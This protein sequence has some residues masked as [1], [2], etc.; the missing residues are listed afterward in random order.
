MAITTRDYNLADSSPVTV[1]NAI[2]SAFTD[3]AWAEA[4]QI[5]Y[6]LTFTNTAGS[7]VSSQINKRYVVA[8]TAASGGT[9]ALFDVLRSPYGGILAVTLVT[10]GSGYSI[11]G[12][13][14]ATGSTTTI[15]VA[16]TT[17]FYA[18]MVV[19][20]LAGGTGVLATNTVI[21]SVT[22]STT[23]VID[24]IPTTALS[25]ASIQVSDVLTLSANNI[26]GT[27]YTT[28]VTATAA[29]TTLTVTDATNI[30]VGQ[31]VTGT[32]IGS[33]VTVTAVN[34]TAVTISKATLNT[35]TAAT[36]TF[37]DE[38]IVTA[39]A[40]ANDSS[41][42]G[43]ITALTITNVPTSAVLHVGQT[44]TISSGS[45]FYT[46]DGR[47]F[48]GAIAGTGPYTVTLR[49]AANTFRGFQGTGNI[50]FKVSQDSTKPWFYYDNFTAPQ[51]YAFGVIK[52][53]NSTDRFGSTF[54]AVYVGLTTTL[55][56]GLTVNIRPMPGFNAVT[57]SAQGVANLDW[58][59]A[60]V[61]TIGSYHLSTTISS[62]WYAPL[63][64]KVRQSSL[65]TNFAVFAF[66][67]GNNTRNPFFI[68][69]FNSNTQ[70]WS[71]NDVFL[72][73]V[74]EIFPTQVI[75][76][77]DVALNFRT[78]LN[79]PKRQAEAGYGNYNLAGTAYT[80]TYFRSTT[81]ARILA[82]PG[83]AYD[84]LMLYSRQT[85]DIQTDLVT[86]TPVYKNIPICPS[87]VPVPYYLPADFVLIEIPWANPAIKDTITVSGSEIY[88]IVQAAT[89]TISTTTLVLAARTT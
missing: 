51:T 24:Q 47:V 2:G 46:G 6:L 26:G 44:V 49:N 33:L 18:G 31:H 77:N 84:N 22:N 45:G 86:T 17:G 11:K 25:G 59:T 35:I 88:T 9:G 73:G 87:F 5:G 85:G 40:I 82:S 65:D 10:G 13:I 53:K 37:S 7:V 8:P 43:T 69:K 83:V 50:T 20:K 38:I 14:S 16:D 54:W 89:N 1:L 55:G 74:Y 29:S 60:A 78:R 67:E 15:T 79:V 36:I 68:S 75:Q 39:S 72:G 80:N 12:S 32:N 63:T 48:I 64:L 81:G 19:T 58:L 28:T 30:Q 27:S 34:N 62:S 56:Q 52:I 76:I 42:P 71:L 3:L 57:S 4:E 70:P 66:L 21:A 23:F 41:I 61:T